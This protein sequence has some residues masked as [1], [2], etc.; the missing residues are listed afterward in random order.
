MQKFYW[1]RSCQSGYQDRNMNSCNE[2]KAGG[3]DKPWQHGNSVEDTNISEETKEANSMDMSSITLT[4]PRKSREQVNMKHSENKNTAQTTDRDAVKVKVVGASSKNMY[5]ILPGGERD[6]RQGSG[7]EIYSIPSDIPIRRRHA[8]KVGQGWN[9]KSKT[10]NQK[11]LSHAL[12][13]CG[14]GQERRKEKRQSVQ[15]IE[16]TKHTYENVY[17]NTNTAREG[18]VNVELAQSRSPLKYDCELPSSNKKTPRSL[19]KAKAGNEVSR[20][21]SCDRGKVGTAV[22]DNMR[23][24]SDRLTSSPGSSTSCSSSTSPPSSIL[25]VAAKAIPCMASTGRTSPTGSLA[26]QSAE[27]DWQ[28]VRKLKVCKEIFCP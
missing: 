7:E 8:D 20:S 18:I 14:I 13:E 19:K 5:R 16:F 2:Y 21:K 4:L 10:W 17:D 11:T 1:P 6:S 15:N 22:L 23:R 26:Y 24:L 28:K 12:Y 9:Q 3:L 25:S 27:Q